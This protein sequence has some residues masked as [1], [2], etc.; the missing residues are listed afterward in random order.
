M[1]G[2]K[3]LSFNELPAAITA[4]A[5]LRTLLRH[6]KQNRFPRPLKIVPHGPYYWPE[7]DVWAWLED[8]VRAAREVQS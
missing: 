1:T 6:S 3:L 7:D 5:N 4:G 2:T 8:R